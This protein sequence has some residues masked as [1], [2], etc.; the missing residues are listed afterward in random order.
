MLLYARTQKE[1]IE[2]ETQV[3]IE[4]QDI[5]SMYDLFDREYLAKA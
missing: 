2:F 3:L 1:R 4:Y 5:K